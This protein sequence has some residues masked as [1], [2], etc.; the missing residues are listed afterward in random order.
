MEDF[1]PIDQEMK[2]DK[3]FLFALV[4]LM[5]SQQEYHMKCLDIRI[6]SLRILLNLHQFDYENQFQWFLAM[7]LIFF[8]L[9]IILPNRKTLWLRKI[10]L[11]G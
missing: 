11:F 3:L 7:A 8:T 10:K 2:K 1:E 5:K 9:D 6:L 4:S